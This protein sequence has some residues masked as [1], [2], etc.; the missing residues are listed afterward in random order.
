MML[1]PGYGYIGSTHNNAKA[2][3]LNFIFAISDQAVLEMTTGNM[4]VRVDD[5]IITRPAVTSAI[6]NGLFDSNVNSWTD[7]DEAGGVSQWVSG[8]FMGLTGTGANAA[9]RTQ[10]VTVAG[11]NIG[12]EHGVRIKIN[13]GVVRFRIG[14]VSGGEDYVSEA[15]LR[16]GEFSFAFTP[17]GDFHISVSAVTKY[18]SRV[19][20]IVVES[21]GAMVIPTPWGLADLP[22]IRYE[23]S[24]D[25]IYVAC[26]GIKQY[27]IERRA[28]RSWGVAEYLVEDGPF[29]LA[30][31]SPT[32]ITPSALIGDITLTASK[33]TFRST[34]VGGLYRVT[35]SGQAVTSSISA[36]NTF[37][38]AVRVTGV[39]SSRTFTVN[40]SGTWSATVTLQRSIGDDISWEDTGT[41]YAV[42]TVTTFSDGLDNQIIFYRLGVKTGNYTS[43]TVVA[44]LV[45]SLGTNPGIARITAFS[46]ATSVSAL[47]L[48]DMGGTAA[49]AD[50]EEGH[51]S[52]RRGYPSAVA[53]D[54]GRLWWGGK[55]NLFGSASDAYESYDDTIEG[56]S[57]PI[58]RSLGTGPVDN[59]N[60][61]LALQRLCVGTGSSEKTV[62][63]SS[64]DEPVTPTAF[65]IKSP[66]TRGSSAV[67]P[68]KIDK[69]GLFVRNGRLFQLEYDGGEFDYQTLDLTLL[70]P[71][72]GKSGFA[73]IAVQRYPDTRVHCIRNDGTAAVLIFNRAEEVKC[74]LDLPTDGFVEDVVVRQAAEN[75]EEDLVSYTVRRTINGVDVR[76]YEK[77]ALES[78]CVG[79]IQNKQADSFIASTQSPSVTITGL[80]HLEGRSVIVWA[81]GINYSPRVAG[82]QTTFVVTSGSITLPAAVTSYVVGLPYKARYKSG[83]LTHAAQGGTAL[84]Q[85]KRVEHLGVIMLNT[86]NRGLRY[87]KDFDTLY[88]MPEYEGGKVVQPNAIWAEYDER[89]FEFE[90]EFDT[91]SRMHLEAMAPMPCTLLAAVMTITTNDRL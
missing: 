46:S 47:V 27:K 22:F 50:W 48:E 87:G 64:F 43:G 7:S 59:I 37:T 61:L 82:V 67:S 51:W 33:A 35:S 84:L 13:R 86:H 53:I 3:H 19:D 60:W 2:N 9:L 91:D 30:N 71:D 36:Q 77:W 90:Q 10:Q 66:S 55:D 18:E 1:R 14:S 89:P 52:P 42:N 28:T 39:G 73:K 8:G 69:S 76:Y 79:G 44:S 17:T 72:V 21:A 85:S 83:K 49:T 45:Y 70:V 6:T 29:R 4:R 78:E 12:V 62:R 56:D 24:G 74:W 32:T 65:N 41:T 5:V 54:E 81:D 80:S 58:V 25:I 16:E 34:S 88:E 31:T 40:I 20:S 15:T 23:Q 68:I 38:S 11:A 57:G 26:K 63:S 75:A